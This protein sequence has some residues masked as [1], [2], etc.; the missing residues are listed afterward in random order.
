[1]AAK[2]K[3]TDQV[4]KELERL[5]GNLEQFDR[6]RKIPTDA[7]FT[8]KVPPK[9]R[10]FETEREER[11]RRKQRQAARG[12]LQRPDVGKPVVADSSVRN[13]VGMVHFVLS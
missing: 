8:L 11:R 4:G 6:G 3:T 13:G 1:M 5:W 7:T 10:S 12:S 2:R 9:S